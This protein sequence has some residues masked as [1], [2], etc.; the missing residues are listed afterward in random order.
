MAKYKIVYDKS[1]CIGAGECAKISGIWKIGSD[2]KADLQGSAKSGETYELEISDS[3]YS[4][5]RQVA[6]SCPS[7]AIK[8]IKLG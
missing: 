6:E 7:Q 2:T 1:A 8:I 3:D 5:Q 4:K